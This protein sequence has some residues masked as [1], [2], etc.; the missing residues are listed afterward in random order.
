MKK[1]MIAL[2]VLAVLGL[3]AVPSYALKNIDDSVPG[4]DFQVP[5]IVKMG[6]TGLD[7][8]VIYQNISASAAIYGPSTG[9]AKRGKFH[10][11]I[12]N[13]TSTE[14]CDQYSTFSR[15]DVVALSVRDLIEA[16][17]TNMKSTLEYDLDGDGT[18]DHYVGYIYFENITAGGA[19]LEDTVAY[20]EYVDL[21]N[22]QASGTYAA[23]REFIDV[24]D[25]NWASQQYSY[26]AGGYTIAPVPLVTTRNLEAFTAS[27]YATTWYRERWETTTTTN[28]IQFTPRWYLHNADSE[29]YIIIWKSANHISAA[30]SLTTQSRVGITVWDNEETVGSG[31][32]YL[33]YELNIIKAS[34]IVPTAYTATYP[35]AGWINITIDG[36]ASGSLG[37]TWAETE[38][39]VYIWQ[40]ASS[41]SAGLNWS[42]LWNDRKVGTAAP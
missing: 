12:Y 34:D 24:S 3:F 13:K 7:T 17:A 16:W 20:F 4:V 23:M 37:E 40:V 28:Y 42:A 15:G 22:G 18:N 9:V 32:I 38:W 2:S 5:F 41:S 26:Y 14:V 6:T 31:T 35:A 8:L 19:A 36:S 21:A 25:T 33:P 27:G 11:V 30:G 29:T 10:W 39:L 1:F